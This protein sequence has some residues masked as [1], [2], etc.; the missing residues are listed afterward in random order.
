MDLQQKEYLVIVQCDIVKQRCPGYLCEKA[1][2]ERTGGFADDPKDTTPRVIN[3]TCGGCC[4]RALH[5]KLSLLKR[6]LKKYE[7]IEKDKILVQFSS[8]ITKDNYHATPCP[9]KDYLIS[10]VEKI[11]ID[12]RQDTV[13]EEKSEKRRQEGIYKS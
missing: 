13:I 2:H 1:L 10:L 9:H 11:G 3:L 4:G 7:N 6:S 5:R 12:Y 8:C